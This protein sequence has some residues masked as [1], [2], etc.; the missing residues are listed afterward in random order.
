MEEIWKDIKDFEGLY[1]ISNLGRVKSLN[2]NRTGKEKILSLLDNGSGYFKVCLCS[3][4]KVKQLYV[5][6]LVA[7]AFIPNPNNLPEVNHKSEIKSQNNVENLEWCTAKYNMNYGT[8]RERTV[9][10]CKGKKRSEEIRNK[11]SESHKGKYNTKCSKPVLQ[12]NKSTNE[13]I[14]EF[15]STKE[16]QRQFG[17]SQ[18]CIS[19]CCNGKRK[20]HKGF[21]WRYKE[22]A[23]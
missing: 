10:K 14:K 3:N 6:R 23:A 19:A 8:A 12:I 13:I 21:I 4:G 20:T 16:V 2:Y 11:L 15:P 17:F 5:H 22:S 18:S 9:E 1:Q 7:E